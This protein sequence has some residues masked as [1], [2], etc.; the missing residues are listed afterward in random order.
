MIG[1]DDAAT[2]L[3]FPG[4]FVKRQIRSAQADAIN[5]SIKSSL[6]RFACLI[7]HEFDARRPAVDREDT[8]LI[9]FLSHTDYAPRVFALSMVA[10]KA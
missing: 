7:Q 6:Q 8:G 4:A 2:V 3:R 1:S 10:Q 9:E 5:L